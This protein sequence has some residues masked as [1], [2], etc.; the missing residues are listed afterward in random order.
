NAQLAFNQRANVRFTALEN[1]INNSIAALEL[2]NRFFLISSD[3][4]REQFRNFTEPL[5]RHYPYIQAFNYHKI[6]AGKDLSSYV[7][8]MRKHYPGFNVNERQGNLLVPVKV[9]DV[10]R[11]VQYVEPFEGNEP[12]LGFDADSY[13]DQ[14]EALQRALAT[15]RPASTDLLVLVQQSEKRHGIVLLMPL[16]RNGVVPDDPVA[17][18]SA[19]TGDTAVVLY[20]SD[21]VEKVM[22]ASGFFRSPGLVVRVYAADTAEPSKLVYSDDK[23]GGQEKKVVSLSVVSP[24]IEPI[25]RTFDFG[26]RVWLMTVE[27]DQAMWLPVVSGSMW[28]LGVGTLFVLLAAAYMHMFAARSARVQILVDQQTLD[29]KHANELL[30]SDIEARERAED[31]LRLRERAIEASANAI[32]LINANGP[33]YHIEYVNPAFERITGYSAQ[34]VLGKSF[35]SLQSEDWEQAGVEELRTALRDR[36]EKHITLRNYRKDGTLYW[37]DVY[38]SP[39]RDASSNVTHF[40]V[41][42]YDVT[43]TKRYEAELEFQANRDSLTGLANRNLLRDRLRQA[44]AYADRYGHPI[45][46]VFVDLDRFKFVN[47]TLGHRAGDLLLSRVAERLLLAVRETD[48]AGRLGGDEF[49]LILPERSD[50]GLSTSVIQ[51]IIEH[52]AAP[53]HVEGHEFFVT[54]SMGVSVY[55]NDGAD[56][57]TLIKHAEVA[58]YRAK[59]MGRNNFQFYTAAMNAESLEKLTLE[60]GLRSAIDRQEFLLHYQPQVDLRSGRIIGMEALIRWKHPDLGMVPPFK[61]IGLAEET[62]QIVPIGQ[63]VTRTACVQAKAWENAG[64]GKLR[65]AVNFSP[66]QFFQGDMVQSV[67]DILE[68]VGLDPECLEIELTES[69]VMTDVE[70]AITIL[71][72][73]KLL[74]VQLS[75]DDFGTGYSSLSYLRRFPIDVLKIDQSFVRDITTDPDDAAIVVSIISLAHSLRL[76]VIAEGVETYEQLAYLTDH[77]CDLMQGYYFSRP[78]ATEDFTELLNEGKH[79]PCAEEEEEDGVRALSGH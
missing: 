64:F 34:E 68:E 8:A 33:D 27:A 65:V 40:V 4:T 9:R 49:A 77:G 43:S 17:R 74:G 67:A 13:R 24:H 42:Q 20:T 2:T 41:T 28:T 51:R 32:V 52:V 21:M 76:K 78:V 62:G 3:V 47:D 54:C 61:F 31:A 25:A 22:K 59:E 69:L 66:R 10:H 15:G 11:V 73:L 71:R 30:K 18:Q 5:L 50:E 44:L 53:L 56:A 60:G 57:D 23:E 35:R 12:A 63:W 46:V 39:V 14:D 75:I 55:P 70:R 45:W 36:V 6:V 1:G 79:L 26:G 19:L 37:H 7:A 38:L 72:E 58:M 29:L 16:Y 48:T